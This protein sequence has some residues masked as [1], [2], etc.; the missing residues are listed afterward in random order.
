MCWSWLPITYLPPFYCEKMAEPL[1]ELKDIHKS[2]GEQQVLKG[3]SLKIR[4]GEVT[5]IIGGSGGGKSVLLKHLVGLVWPD[6]GQILIEGKPLA[7]MSKKD[8]RALKRKFSYMFQGSALFDSMTVYEN[9]ALPLKERSRMHPAEIRKRVDDKMQQL[10]L[11]GNEDKYPSQLSGGMKKRVALARALVTD[12]EIVLFDEPTTGLD[13]VRKN[14]V[15]GMISDH[16]KKFGFTAVVVSHE[17]PDIFYICQ[18]VAMLFEGK[19]LMQS[20]P[21]EFQRSSDPVIQN[22]IHGLESDNNEMMNGLSTHKQARTRYRE[23][24]VHLRRSEI[25]FSMI[26]LT[27]TNLEQLNEK[28]GYLATQEIL[29][30]FVGEVRKRIE[31]TDTCSLYGLDKIILVL[32]NADRQRAKEFC[33][34]LAKEIQG[35]HLVAIQPYPGF[36]FCISAGFAQAQKDSSYQDVLRMAESEQNIFLEFRVC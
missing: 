22:F 10:E 4:K 19:I 3:A 18:S 33:A 26:V 35:E 14:A 17:I 1:I 30:R 16:Q 24:M 11:G 25:A 13:P 31:I 12:P 29:R 15:H 32:S 21:D 20:T 36:C 34:R 8:K 28:L 23:A 9:I 6:S 2:F 27:M 7:S 5:A